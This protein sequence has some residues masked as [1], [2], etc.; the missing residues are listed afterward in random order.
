MDQ[1]DTFLNEIIDKKQ[2]PGIDE[3][4]KKQLIADMKERLLDRINRALIDQLSDENIAKMSQ[5]IDENPE[6]EEIVQEFLVNSGVDVRKVTAKVMLSFQAYYLE[7]SQ[8]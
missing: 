2:L 5:L 6:N 4:V 1:I 7:G 8:E 3:A